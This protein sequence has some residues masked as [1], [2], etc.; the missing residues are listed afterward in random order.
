ME[1]VSCSVFQLLD[2]Q[3]TWVN[4]ST[5]PYDNWQ[6]SL[7][8]WVDSENIQNTPCHLTLG[9][10]F[11]QLLQVERPSSVPDEELAQALRWTIKD[12]VSTDGEL[13]VDYFDLPIQGLGAPKVNVVAAQS[14]KVAELTEGAQVAGLLVQDVNVEE[15]I[16]CDFFNQDSE[17][18]ALLMQEKNS[19][20]CMSIVKDG[21]IYFSRRLRGYEKLSNF[22]ADEL[23]M[24]LIDN[25]ALEV[26][27]SMD[28]F[29]SQLRQSPVR[30]IKLKLD[31]P[32][33]STICDIV[34]QSTQ[35]DVSEYKFDI[36]KSP[37]LNFN[38]SS[39]V[40]I[41]TGYSMRE[42]DNHEN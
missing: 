13:A 29:E 22:S 7:A 32:E 26:Q 24:G 33:T 12:L 1:G 10:S 8:K 31:S 14:E 19:E 20:I 39:Y 18:T 36:A 9:V 23:R 2:G 35:V 6:L 38:E 25:L 4:Q 42:S 34:H 27:R 16:Y 40:A 28:Y 5:F 3:L 21:Q 41:A 30:K 11:Y 37:H 17:P 15:L